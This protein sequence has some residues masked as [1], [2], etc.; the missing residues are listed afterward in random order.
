MIYEDNDWRFRF[1][2]GKGRTT[3]GDVFLRSRRFMAL[4]AFANFFDS[5]P[6][7][8]G[9]SRREKV[10]DSTRMSRREGRPWYRV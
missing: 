5:L 10:L 7:V 1:R 4:S 9:F 2:T 3:I 6:R 8:Q